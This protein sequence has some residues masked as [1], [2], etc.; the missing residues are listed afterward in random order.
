MSPA[1]G[2]AS[3]RQPAALRDLER[4][5]EQRGC[6]HARDELLSRHTS[7][8]I[9][10]PCP[11]MIWPRR[12]GDVRALAEW[13]GGRGLAWRVLGGGTNVLVA[14]RGVDDVVLATG[15]LDAGDAY[16]VDG[17]RLP[18]GMP[19]ARALRRTA[20]H[21]LDGLVWAAGLPGSVGGAAAGNS[22]CWGGE[23][24][25]VVTRLEIVDARGRAHDIDSTS[26]GWE[27]RRLQLPADLPEPLAIVGVHVRLHQG[28]AAALEERYLALQERK[29]ET[30]PVGARNSG[31]V[32]RNPDAEHA[33]G[34]LIEG[35]GCKGLRVG[36]ASVSEVHANF[37]I[38]HGDATAADVEHLVRD[39]RR[40]VDERFGVR[41]RVEI[42]R[43]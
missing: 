36:G 27:Y 17:A 24:A 42:R 10:G 40:R 7:M 21:G 2:P 43:W 38:N 6:R 23:M 14:D 13:M 22:G 31:C 5:A 35:A 15:D 11:L 1:F 26:L 39:V 29:R 3:E 8:G 19:T 18:A 20:R 33:A 32:F 16:T 9:G 30:Q 28:D 37:V 4:M 12:P 34:R 41:L 25:D